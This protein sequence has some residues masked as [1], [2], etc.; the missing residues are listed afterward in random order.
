MNDQLIKFME[1]M[2]QMD[3]EGGI[4][5]IIRHGHDTTGFADLDDAMARVQQALDK[6]D[7]LINDVC[8]KYN[9]EIESLREARSSDATDHC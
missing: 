1:F 5:G 2:D 6:V 8:D 4:E 9:T 3:W 7:S